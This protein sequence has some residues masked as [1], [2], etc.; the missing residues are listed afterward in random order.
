MNYREVLRRLQRHDSRIEELPARG[1]GSHRIIHH[2][3]LGQSYP[4]KYHGAKT[5]IPPAVLNQLSR[6]FDLPDGFWRQ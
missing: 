3:G 1:K 6:K 5:H 2:T 4:L